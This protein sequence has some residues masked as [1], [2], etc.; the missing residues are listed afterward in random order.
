[1]QTPLNRP[2]NIIFQEGHSKRLEIVRPT[3]KHKKSL[4]VVTDSSFKREILFGWDTVSVLRKSG[5]A[6]EHYKLECL[7]PEQISSLSIPEHSTVL[8]AIN[9]KPEELPGC[10]E[11]IGSRSAAQYNVIFDCWQENNVHLD[12]AVNITFLD[13]M[14]KVAVGGFKNAGDE[15]KEFIVLI[16]PQGWQKAS[17]NLGLALIAGALK[18]FGFRPVIF[19]LN[20]NNYTDEEL[21][22][23]ISRLKPLAIGYSAKTAT[24]NE[25]VRLCRYLKAHFPQTKMVIGGPHVTL[26]GHDLLKEQD[27]FD[28]GVVSESEIAASK[29]FL[30]YAGGLLPFDTGNVIYRQNNEVAENSFSPPQDI[31]FPFWPDFDCIHRFIV[32]RL[33]PHGGVPF[34]AFTVA[35][36]NLRGTKNG[37]AELQSMYLQNSNMSKQSII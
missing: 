37:A 34:S 36:T 9:G 7:G 14:G 8:Y 28:A 12:S 32:I 6:I 10:I 26:C 31:N 3:V 11:A 5:Y 18:M 19:D 23:E 2:D 33:L 29:V 21:K 24:V 13:L 20:L 25:A 30:H 1:M 27:V 17:T 15:C 22:D 4:V 35:S 16:N